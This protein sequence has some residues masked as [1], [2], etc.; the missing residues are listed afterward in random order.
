MALARPWKLLGSRGNLFASALEKIWGITGTIKNLPERPIWLVNAT[1]YETGRNWRFSRNHIGDWKFGHNYV[2]DVPISVAM[3]ASAAIPY[4]AGFVKLKLNPKG[5]Y[6]IDQATEE[7]LKET[8]LK[9]PYVRLWDGGVYENL[10]IEG[11]W[12]PGGLVNRDVEFLVVSDGSGYLREDLARA[13]GVFTVRPPFLRGPR[14]FDIA[15]EQTR[16]LRVRILMDAVTQRKLPASI[17][18]L[19]RSAQDIDS[20]AKLTR[21]PTTPGM[22]LSENEVEQA[23]RFATN[24]SKMRHRDF[25][26]LLR[27][28]FETADATLTVHAGAVFQ[29]SFLWTDATTVLGTIGGATPV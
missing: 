7:R 14:L 19:G 6:E 26:L 24:A 27:H 17:V 22:L 3:A 25:D 20:Q 15:S 12:K 4:M 18:R 28:G 29:R 13:T 21:G 8:Q 5:W 11:V 2:Q 1:T 9:R 23:S 16:S 10:G